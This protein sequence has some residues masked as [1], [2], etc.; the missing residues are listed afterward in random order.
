M[1][2][3]QKTWFWLIGLVAVVAA[4]YYLRPILLPFVAAMGVAYFLDP[5]C[6][7]LEE[8]GLSR[9][10]ATGAVTAVFFVVV[11]LVLVAVSPLIYKQV[12]ELIARVPSYVAAM[13][14]KLGPLLDLAADRLGQEEV[15]DL[16]KSATQYAGTALKWVASAVGEVLGGLGAVANIISLI[17]ITPIISF[18][19]LRDWDR[20]VEKVD[21][22]L[23]R[24]QADTLR[25]LA[26]EVDDIL[27][28]FARGQATVCLI[29]GVLYG[30]GLTIVGLDFGFIVGLFTGLVSFIPYFGM[31]IGFV[32]GFGIALA[33][34]DSFTPLLLVA[35]VFAVGQVVEGNFLTPKLVGGR[36]K[37]HEVWIIFALMAGGTLFGFVGILIAVPVAA[38]VGVLARFMIAQYLESPLYEHGAP[39]GGAIAQMP[40]SNEPSGSDPETDDADATEGD[41]PAK[42]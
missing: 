31:L 35:A 40:A 42:P 16:G 17:V 34:F 25:G 20:I 39:L 23:P 22:W 5:V 32:L 15:K 27:A 14:V 6:D 21:T 13:Q 10:M 41:P 37:L 12:A 9:T 19:L 30:V 8:K 3:Q 4:L 2:T 26:K 38:V 28:G 29:L 24:A 18:Y 33:Q 7:W 1:T 36:V 11:T